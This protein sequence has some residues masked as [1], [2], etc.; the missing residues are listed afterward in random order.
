MIAIY[1]LMQNTN[2][3]T[4]DPRHG[5]LIQSFFRHFISDDNF[6]GAEGT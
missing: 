2:P 4:P 3:I 1:T 6:F 5:S